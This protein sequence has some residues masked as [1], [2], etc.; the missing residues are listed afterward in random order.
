MGRLILASASP[1]RQELLR[2]AGYEFLSYPA[3]V[4]E[5]AV[6]RQKSVTLSPENLAVHLAGI[7]ARMVAE[8]F[9][10]DVV[11]AAD[12]IVAMGSEILGKPLDANDA[13]RILTLL[14]G[15][16]H[17]VITGMAVVSRRNAVTVSEAVASTVEMRPLSS[18]EIE[19][20]IATNQWQGKAGAYGIQDADPFVTRVAGC[21]TNIVGLP[22]TTTARLLR[23][24]G[25]EPREIRN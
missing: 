3:D 23:A 22:M 6:A 14:S 24:A 18:G 15:T 11:L 8:R 1:R 21:T 2:E 17:R 9:P 16:T 5:A 7:K 13:R 25:I 19:A 20:Y 10:D 4:D 12:T